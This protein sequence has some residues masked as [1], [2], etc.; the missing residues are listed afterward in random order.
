MYPTNSLFGSFYSFM[1]YKNISSILGGRLKTIINCG[2]PTFPREL[3]QKLS[4]T[5]NIWIGEE[6]GL[7]ETGGVACISWRDDIHLDNV[8]GPHKICRI[9]LRD[10]PQFDIY[11]YDDPPRGEICIS[12]PNI[13]PGYFNNEH[14]NKLN[15]DENGWL[16]TGDYGRVLS[17]G[18][19]EVVDRIHNL[20]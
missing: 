13:T 2:P 10:I 20:F 12:G 18:S 1:G 11:H 7:L 9:K 4:D 14:F 15:F 16:R 8:G 6:Y 3:R 5:F 17:N 19:I